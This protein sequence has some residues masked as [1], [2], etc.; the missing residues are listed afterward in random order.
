MD[1]TGR[2]LLPS[3]V[4]ELERVC[5]VGAEKYILLFAGDKQQYDN[6]IP[7]KLSNSP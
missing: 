7:K 3:S 2:I 4:G 6:Y 5:F 1:N